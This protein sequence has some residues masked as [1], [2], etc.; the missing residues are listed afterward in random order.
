MGI[1]LNKSDKNPLASFFE[2]NFDFL[3]LQ[4]AHIDLTIYFLFLVINPFEF[5]SL[6]GF[7]HFKQYV[8]II[9]NYIS[10]FSKL[11]LWNCNRNLI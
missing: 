4:I 7:L 10:F 3:D 9:Y 8:F 1:L 6:V 5:K 11:F 2:T